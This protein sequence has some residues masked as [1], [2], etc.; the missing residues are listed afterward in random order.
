MGMLPE[1]LR[2]LVADTSQ[3][4]QL[5]ADLPAIIAVTA[6]AGV[7]NHRAVM[8]PKQQDT[9]WT[10]T[11]NLWAA[12][13]APPGFLKSP[14]IEVGT[15][16]LRRIEKDWKEQYD[17]DLKAYALAAEEH[18]L[19]LRVWEQQFIHAKKHKRP[20]PPRPEDIG[21]EP[22][23][24]RLIAN[25]STYEKLH[26]LMFQ[27]PSGL[28]L[29]RDE[30]TGLLSR[31]DREEHAGERAFFLQ[32]WN[33]DTPLV[34]DRI[35]RGTLDVR[36][37][38]LSVLGGI[39]P[40]R[41]RAYLAA[42]LRPGLSGDGLPQRHQLAIWPDFPEAW[43]YVDRPP[44]QAAE[45]QA[46]RMYERLV[47]IGSDAPLRLGFS[48]PGAGA[49]YCMAKGTGGAGARKRSFGQPRQSFRQIPLLAAELGAAI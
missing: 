16:A 44:D 46:S 30:L 35:Q 28:L 33:G 39:T 31:L 36:W 40:A 9:T 12:L 20:P 23:R 24:R 29:I 21:E 27:N 19:S 37:C 13:I 22:M 4:M 1:S 18:K 2:P 25:D 5:P 34:V 6:L 17:Q 26:Q 49:V 11:P 10:V 38:C 32:A 48:P 15:R 14:A 45:Q 47:R 41:L 7:V 42:P 43:E 3:R 8:Q